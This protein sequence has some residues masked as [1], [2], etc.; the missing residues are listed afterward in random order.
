[1]AA[2][3]SHE[4]R[5]LCNGIG[6]I[7]SGLKK[8]PSLS[9][10]P[11]FQ[12]LGELVKGLHE[13][14]SLDLHSRSNEALE[15]VQLR[16]VLGT[17]RIII[18]PDWDEIDGTIQWQIPPNTPAVQ[19]DSHGLLQAL[20]NLARNSHR[21]VQHQPARLLSLAASSCREKAIIQVRDSGH[22]RAPQPLSSFFKRTPQLMG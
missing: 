5:N 3:A 21:A 2:A 11:G 7:Y 16:Q 14:A 19:A 20:L 4:I 18:Q 22:S 12:A 8:S 15:P 10:D 13:M 6:L 1:M 9:S 17:L